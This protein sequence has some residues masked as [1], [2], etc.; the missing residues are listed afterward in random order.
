MDALDTDGDGTANHLDIDSDG[1]GLSDLSEVGGDD[2]NNDGLVDAWTDSDGD[3]IIDAVDVDL[4][5]GTDED[6]DGIDDFADAD[7]INAT[8]SDGD[9]I[10]DMFDDDF[11][12]TGF[13][14][15]TVVGDAGD[16]R[17]LPDENL[18]NIPDVLQANLE[19]AAATPEEIHTGLA[20]S[21]CSVSPGDAAKDPMLATTAFFAA[22]LVFWRRMR[23]KA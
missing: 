21:G 2:L 20:G 6:G 7:Y 12:G 11:L 15:F 8:D 16:T 23:R 4:T 14:P 17:E 13:L 5:G 3:G 19:P 18:D 10:I 22:L 1:D 9:G